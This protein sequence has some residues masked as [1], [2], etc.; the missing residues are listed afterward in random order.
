MP[1]GRSAPRRRFKA[2][3][4]DVGGTLVEDRDFGEFGAI[5]EHLEISAH[6]EAIA[7]AVR[8]ADRTLDHEGTRTSPDEYWREV[9]G[10]ASGKEVPL[11]A[12]HR[13]VE[14]IERLPRVA[15]LFSDVR[16]TLERL[17]SEGRRLGIIS[18]SRSE[19]AL[20]ELLES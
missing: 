17:K 9:L 4:F 10:R 15:Q 13:F 16:R 5:A 3:F 8:W 14:R 11:S 19:G 1:W 20:K 12:A 2:V 18:N 7:E 6:P